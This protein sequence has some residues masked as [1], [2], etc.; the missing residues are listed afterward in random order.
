MGSRAR[1]SQHIRRLQ[2]FA[3]MESGFIEFKAPSSYNYLAIIVAISNIANKDQQSKI[4]Q[5]RSSGT[6]SIPN[7][8]TWIGIGCPALPTPYLSQNSYRH[9]DS[10]A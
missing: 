4:H 10:A 9:L 8:G 7:L 3:R 1:T 5:E 6:S 2:V